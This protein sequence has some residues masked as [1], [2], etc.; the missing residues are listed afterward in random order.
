MAIDV[1]DRVAALA[2]ACQ[3][4]RD[5]LERAEQSGNGV[6][7]G[8]CRQRL[9]VAEKRLSVKDRF[10]ALLEKLSTEDRLFHLDDSPESIINI[11]SGQRIFTDK[12]ADEIG[13]LVDEARS[14]L[15]ND[16]IWELAWPLLNP[17]EA[18]DGPGAGPG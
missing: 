6:A 3:A 14:L 15:G 18:G 8:I 17:P 1:N 2:I 7:A 5:A 4:E 10:M 11:A 9:E 12:E 16:L 13:D